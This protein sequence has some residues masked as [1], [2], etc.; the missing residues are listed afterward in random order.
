MVF[1]GAICMRFVGFFWLA[2]SACFA[3]HASAT[4][5]YQVELENGF[6]IIVHSAPARRVGERVALRLIVEAGSADE[7]EG[8]TGWAH[9]IEHMAFLGAGRFSR[10]DIDRLYDQPALRHGRDFNAYTDTRHTVYTA[11]VPRERDDVIDDTLELMRA[12]L[13]DMHFKPEEVAREFGVVHTELLSAASPVHERAEAA[14]LALIDAPTPVPHGASKLSIDRPEPRQLKAFWASLYDLSRATLV[15][16]GDLDAIEIARRAT[17]LFGS[18]RARLAPRSDERAGV[19][20]EEAEGRFQT[21]VQYNPYFLEPRLSYGLMPGHSKQ[22]QR[23]TIIATEALLHW[24]SQSAAVQANC[25]PVFRDRVRRNT[26]DFAYFL[27]S[28]P[29]ETN[30]DHC[31]SQLEH[32]AA[33]QIDSLSEQSWRVLR[34]VIASR[35]RSARPYA[36]LS[37]AAHVADETVQHVIAGLDLERQRDRT[38]GASTYLA[39][40]NADAAGSV[41]RAGLSVPRSVVAYESGQERLSPGFAVR[42]RQF[43]ERMSGVDA[44]LAQPEMQAKRSMSNPRTTQHV[45]TNQRAQIVGEQIET[46]G[47]RVLHLD[48]GLTIHHLPAANPSDRLA[49]MVL[50][51]NN[52]LDAP[53]VITNAARALPALFDMSVESP[54]SA[55]PAIAVARSRGIGASLFVETMRQGLVLEAHEAELLPAFQLIG[56]ALRDGFV[57]DS[58]AAPFAERLNSRW[59]SVRSSNARVLRDVLYRS[60]YA[61]PSSTQH[62]LPELQTLQAAHRRFFVESAETEIILVGELPAASL[63]QLLESTLGGLA[64]RGAG[65]ESRLE[66]SPQNHIIR[67]STSTRAA[68]ISVHYLQAADNQVDLGTAKLLALQGALERALRVHL[69]EQLGL[70]YQLSVQLIRRP[71]ARGGTSLVVHTRTSPEEVQRVLK[72]IDATVSALQTD[73]IPDATRERL[74]HHLI[75]D[76]ADRR[77]SNRGLI[78]EYALMREH[79]LGFAQI[80]EVD[81]N[82][83][84]LESDSLRKFAERFFTQAGR[85]ALV[86][87]PPMSSAKQVDWQQ[88]ADRATGGHKSSLAKQLSAEIDQ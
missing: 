22:S 47:A 70:I 45:A 23:D 74:Q 24:W 65:V 44:E 85:V 34:T 3:P 63:R 64:E 18:D 21:L 58:L 36:P 20:L 50:N 69:R 42:L 48:S 8:S 19:P 57:A 5:P 15:V 81:A 43:A 75:T 79:E 61:I 1:T 62:A 27:V 78:Y 29:V 60:F 38:H 76:Y 32:E 14:W 46:N 13:T 49:I 68:D 12:W 77:S 10:A 53:P 16:V 84:R 2:V 11:S 66:P 67:V 55:T 80:A 72:G 87:G 40:L 86:M 51:R 82:L 54:R 26:R 30:L 59:S 73:R 88:V 56:H 39:S 17:A 6:R 52:L 41:I 71:Y 25:G 7:R 4:S 83:R 33:R 31:L 28:T 9:L 37:S 35:L